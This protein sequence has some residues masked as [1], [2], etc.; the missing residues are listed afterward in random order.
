MSDLTPEQI[1]YELDQMVLDGLIVLVG[2]DETTGD[3]LYKLAEG[4]QSHE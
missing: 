3:P 1:Q 4:W 2:T